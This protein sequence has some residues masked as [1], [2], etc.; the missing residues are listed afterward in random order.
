MD[1]L[2]INEEELYKFESLKQ[3]HVELDISHVC[4]IMFNFP[5]NILLCLLQSFGFP[6]QITRE[7]VFESQK[8]GG[9]VMD[10][11]GIGEEDMDQHEMGEDGMEQVVESIGG[12]RGFEQIRGALHGK[13]TQCYVVIEIG[14]RWDGGA[15]NRGERAQ[16]ADIVQERGRY[17]Q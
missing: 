16:L 1:Y 17:R 9:E 14:S 7:I 12:K 11:E 5:N 6:S 8:S 13:D 3:V 10:Q 4:F 2:G 15:S